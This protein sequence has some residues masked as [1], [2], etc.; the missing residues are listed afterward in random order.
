M[1]LADLNVG[2]YEVR[3]EGVGAAEHHVLTRRL[4]VV[5]DDLE[6]AGPV[7]GGDGLRILTNFVKISEVG[8]DDGRA[9]A[10]HADPAPHV[11]VGRTVD[12]AAIE[13]DVGGDLAE[14][15]LPAERFERDEADN[16]C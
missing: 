14:V 8:V 6:G 11:P 15:G 13:D 12:I 1:V 4:E 3:N 5:I 10:L 16:R 7:P 9:G 2:G